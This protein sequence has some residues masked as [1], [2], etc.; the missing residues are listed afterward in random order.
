MTSAVV[1]KNIYCNITYWANTPALGADITLRSGTAPSENVLKW[2][3]R[4]ITQQSTTSRQA[5]SSFL[6]G[7]QGVHGVF[8]L[9]GKEISNWVFQI[10][11]LT[12]PLIHLLQTSIGDDVWVVAFADAFGEMFA[13]N[14]LWGSVGRY[15]CPVHWILPISGPFPCLLL[16]IV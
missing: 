16:H 4:A 8:F 9:K 15:R 7:R 14:I 10:R 12:S 13:C 11:F 2:G 1:I 3:S 6:I 5:Q